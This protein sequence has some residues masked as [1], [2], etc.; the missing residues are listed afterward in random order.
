MKYLLAVLVFIAAHLVMLYL[1]W[2]GNTPIERGHDLLGAALM[3]LMWGAVGAWAVVYLY[4][5]DVK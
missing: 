3:G 1:M 2:I 5:G 4:K